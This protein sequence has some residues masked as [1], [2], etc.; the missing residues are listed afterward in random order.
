MENKETK[1]FEEW[2]EYDERGNLIL[3]NK[4][5]NSHVCLKTVKILIIEIKEAKAI[6]NFIL[7]LL[8]IFFWLL[9]RI[10]GSIK[11]GRLYIIIGNILD[12]LILKILSNTYKSIFELLPK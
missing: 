12:D 5:P 1:V 9:S 10:R 6:A 4:L 2:R 8:E 7:I 11:I 3:F